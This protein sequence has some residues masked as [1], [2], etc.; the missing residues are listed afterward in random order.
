MDGWNTSFRMAYFQGRDV[1]FREGTPFFPKGW[2]LLYPQS[3]HISWD[4]YLLH[5]KIPA[6]YVI[7]DF[8]LF[9]F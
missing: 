9:R 7:T 4:G 1:S 2:L 8:C 6:T 5:M 3:N